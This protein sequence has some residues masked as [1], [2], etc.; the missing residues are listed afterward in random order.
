MEDQTKKIRLWL[1]LLAF[2]AGFSTPTVFCQDPVT[3]KITPSTR[4]IDPFHLD[5][6]C[7]NGQPGD[8]ICIPVTVE[9]FVDIVIVQMEITWNSNVL[10]YI[11][12]QNPGT[13]SINVNSDFNLSGPNALKFIPLGFPINGESLPDGT[14]LFEICF[15]II[16]TPGSMSCVGISPYFPY[17]AADINGE[18]PSD[19]D[20]CC[21]TVDNAMNLVGFLTS[22]GPDMAGNNGTID[23]SIFGGTAPYTITWDDHMGNTGGPVPVNMEGGNTMINVPCSTYDVTITDALGNNV[24]YTIEVDCLGL[25]VVTNIKHPTCYKFDNGIIWIK[26][27]GGS[28]PFSYIW[29]SLY[30]PSKAG[31]GFIRNPGDSSQITSL[32]DGVYSIT[33]EDDNGCEVIVLDTILDNPFVFTVNNFQNATCNGSTNG[34]IDLT[35]S[36]ARPDASG[37]Y[38]VKGLPPLPSFTIQTNAITIGLLNPGDYCIMVSDQVSQCDTVYCFSIGYSDTISATLT[39]TDP[40]CHDDMTGQVSMRGR[41]N[42]A[43]MPPYDYFVYNTNNTLVHSQLN[44][45]GLYTSPAILGPG[46][47]KGVV[48]SANGCISDTI[49]FTI[50]NPPPMTVTVAGSNPDN[51][52]PT[53]SGD[54]WFSIMGGTGPYILDAGV[55]FQDGDT[56]FNMN[57]GN[58]MVTVTDVNGCTAKIP[59]H[60]PSYD[61]NEEGDITFQIDGTPCEGGQLI[62]LYQGMPIPANVGILWSNGET[63]DTI[64]ITETDTLSVDV[65]L[66]PPIF[67]ILNDTVHVDCEVKLDIDIT[68][69]QPLCGEGAVGG[70]YTATVIADT[71]NAV[72]PVTWYWSF[73]DT[74]TT[75]IYAGVLPGKYYVTVVDG[76]DSTAVDSFEVIAPNPLHLS[77]SNVDSTSC[78]EACD[79]TATVL[80]SNGDP[81]LDYFLYWTSGTQQADTGVIFNISNLCAGENIFDVSQDGICFYRDTVEILAPDSIDINL[82]NAVDASC[83]GKKDGS[84]QVVASGGTPGYTYS[85]TGGPMNATFS[86]IAAGT[87]HVFATDS[88]NCMVEDSFSIGQPDTLIAIIDTAVQIS[89]GNTNDGVIILNV[90]GGNPGGYTYTWDPNVSDTYQAANLAAGDYHITVSDPKGCQ[91]TTSYT[92][93]APLPVQ[94]VWPVID[95]PLCFGDVSD[96]VI[97]DVSGGSGNYTYSVN[98]GEQFNIGETISLPAGIYLIVVSDDRGCFDDTT[99]MIIEPNPILVS[100]GPDDPVINL[101]DSLY[102]TGSVDQSDLPINTT[103]WTSEAPMSC[104]TC[105]GTWVYNS[106]PTLYTWTVTDINGCIGSASILVNVD[107]DRDVYVPNI[108]SPNNDG[109]ND[110]FK[111]FTGLGVTGV[112]YFRIYDRW[113]NLIHE[114]KDLLP[115]ANGVG[116]W[117]GTF[118]GDP[119][120]PGVYIFVAEITFIDNATLTYKGDITLVK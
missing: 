108:F 113:G 83:F 90:S 92:L 11:K 91:D 80:A 103:L 58:Y 78:P 69:Q 61:E 60:V 50:N 26:P 94:A 29:E 55:G 84:L 74:T 111:I 38:L 114:E 66:G 34:L 31:S 35:I 72:P 89:C 41:T 88:K 33:I 93:S 77:F 32:K 28:A 24:T 4:G 63:N 75:G 36:G 23:V 87:F 99:Y 45:G 64:P 42:G 54:V 20:S 53:P 51:C 105:E 8:T 81:N 2:F 46:N 5:F 118:N 17:Q 117:D 18:I 98:G 95:P 7:I 44:V 49:L 14:V 96:F 15:R 104:P 56:L 25:S 115:D 52:I 67:C 30:D 120:N 3:I 37:N 73:P 43:P 102:I 79:G 101:G 82:V 59:F 40:P 48:I 116:K 62:V 110:D 10:D 65:L 22:C 57:S 112:N 47:Y 100:I 119:L 68:V 19:F 76:N 71:S 106:V 16:G 27:G 39:M 70:P 107:Y 6:N 86:G 13:P 97:N 85:W 9:N 1:L 109:R 12:V 21:M